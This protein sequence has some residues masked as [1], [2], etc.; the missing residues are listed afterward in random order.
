MLGG[1][2]S[3]IIT[4]AHSGKVLDVAGAG[5]QDGANVYQWARH[6]GSNQQWKLEAV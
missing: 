2:R 3:F 4:A 5:Q 1:G 6:G